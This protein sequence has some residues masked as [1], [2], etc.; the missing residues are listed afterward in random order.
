MG[1]AD[2]KPFDP[3]LPPPLNAM[4]L[5]QLD[6]Y[7]DYYDK[8]FVADECTPL[9]PEM[10]AISERA[11]RKLPDPP[12]PTKTIRV[13]LRPDLVQRT[14]AEADR[15]GTSRDAVIAD[16]LEKALSA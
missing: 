12:R 6:A 7:S 9:T 3:T 11:A 4:T 14:Q 10:R 5:E 16:V 15:R 1:N 13:N 2:D 8:E